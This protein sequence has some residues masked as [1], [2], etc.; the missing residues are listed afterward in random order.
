MKRYE[1]IREF[2]GLIFIVGMFYFFMVFGSAL[3]ADDKLSAIWNP[4]TSSTVQGTR[5]FEMICNTPWTGDIEMDAQCSGPVDGIL[6]VDRMRHPGVNDCSPL[7]IEGNDCY[8]YS[9]DGFYT[10]REGLVCFATTAYNQTMESP[11]GPIH[12]EFVELKPEP[13]EPVEPPFE[14][15]I[16][17]VCDPDCTVQ[18]V[19]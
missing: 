15:N 17:L 18:I 4:S 11:Y 10:G 3:Y 8:T 13:V 7:G 19:P 16:K 6:V 5:L 12:C 1:V 2:F 9:K 14:I